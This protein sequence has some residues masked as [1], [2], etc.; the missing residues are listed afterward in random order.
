MRK[1]R[2]NSSEH[3]N[4]MSMREKLYVR[5]DEALESNN[6]DEVE[7][8]EDR[9]SE[10]HGPVFLSGF[11]DFAR[12]YPDLFPAFPDEQLV[13]GSQIFYGGNTC[14]VCHCHCVG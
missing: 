4:L 10:T 14:A 8:A 12:Q 5:R 11:C 13:A 1:Y 7:A 3:F 2:V 6:W 9:I